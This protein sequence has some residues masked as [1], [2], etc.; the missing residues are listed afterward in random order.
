MR[1]YSSDVKTN[2]KDTSELDPCLAARSRVKKN[3]FARWYLFC[4]FHSATG[5]LFPLLEPCFRKKW[6]TIG[7][8]LFVLLLII[9]VGLLVFF[10]LP[11]KEDKPTME[12]VHQEIE[13]PPS[14]YDA[15]VGFSNFFLLNGYRKWDKNSRRIFIRVHCYWQNSMKFHCCKGMPDT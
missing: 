7:V 14:D 1:K 9:T 12:Y 15:E 10:L 5:F 4:F 6:I 3:F 11:L 2:G 8:L 13:V